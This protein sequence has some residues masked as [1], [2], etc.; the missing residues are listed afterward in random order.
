MRTGRREGNICYLND[1]RSLSTIEFHKKVV[2]LDTTT[3]K[4]ATVTVYV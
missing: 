4:S 2:E 1:D 3:K